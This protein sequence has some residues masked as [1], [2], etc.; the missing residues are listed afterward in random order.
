MKKILDLGCGSGNLTNY[1]FNKNKNSFLWRIDISKENIQRAEK[2]KISK[3]QKFIVGNAENLPFKSNFFSEIYCYEV[4]EHVENLQE[5]LLEIK[6]VL[7]KGGRF[8]LTVPLEESEKV[9][10]KYNKEYPQQIGHRRFFSRKKIGEILSNHKFKIIS[11]RAF[12]SIEHLFWKNAFK[13]GG[14]IINQLGELDKRPS[15][16]IRISNL[17][18]SRELFY[19]RDMTKNKYYKFIMNFFVLFYPITFFLDLILL[20]KKQI[21][22]T[23]NEK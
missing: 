22:V 16:I 14:K 10:I 9:L 3:M 8:I 1:L 20:N 5:V 4:L 17:A 13:R 2:N 21:V 15:R 12:N 6:R 11:Y 23:T 19:Q 18:F 7:K